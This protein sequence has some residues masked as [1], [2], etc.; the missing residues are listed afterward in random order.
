MRQLTPRQ[1]A[2]CQAFIECGVLTDAYK[3]AFNTKAAHRSIVN[4][5]SKLAQVPT[6][7]ARIIEL[8]DERPECDA[9]NLKQEEFCRQVVKLGSITDAYIAAYQMTCS[10]E[11]ARKNAHR[12]AIRP[13]IAARIAT[14]RGE[15]AERQDM[16]I[17]MIAEQLEEDHAFA[18]RMLNP[19]AAISA[20]VAMAKLYGFMGEKVEH[21]HTMK[22]EE[23]RQFIAAMH[24][25]YGGNVIEGNFQRLPE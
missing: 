7:A 1:E 11:G 16:T 5:A 9:L 6:V 24:S 8:R 23:A 4:L 18:V 21:S 3:A 12:L 2:F 10:R 19:S 20:T 13:T 14:L 15:L 17:D 22:V 25:K